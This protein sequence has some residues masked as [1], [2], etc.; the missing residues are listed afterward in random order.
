MMFFRHIITNNWIR[1]RDGNKMASEAAP[2]V[3][4]SVFQKLV[5]KTETVEAEKRGGAKSYISPEIKH[6]ML[7]FC[8]AICE[9]LQEGVFEEVLTLSKGIANECCDALKNGNK[10]LVKEAAGFAVAGIEM[11]VACGGALVRYG[12]KDSSK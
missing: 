10:E 3:Q 6:Q 11:G 7:V 12:S 2:L 8:G 4:E 1:E 5:Q 9:A